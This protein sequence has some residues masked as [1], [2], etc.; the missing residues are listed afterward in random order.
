MEY[1][2]TIKEYALLIFTVAQWHAFIMMMIVTSSLTETAKRVFFIRMGKIKKKQWL[3]GTAF[4]VGI[5]AS[6][7][8]SQLGEPTIPTWF[9]Y[10][11]A[12]I[13]GPVSNMIHW[14]TLGLIGWKFPKLAD[15]L[16]GKKT[17]DTN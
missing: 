3:Y 17:N 14:L 7:A 13:V 12:I 5:V 15:A 16:K 10:V 6:I 8:G 4:V 9:W 11:A 1:I 2:N